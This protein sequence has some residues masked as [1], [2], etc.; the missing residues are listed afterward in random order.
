MSSKIA[1]AKKIKGGYFYKGKSEK[2]LVKK[3]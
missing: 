1:T 2:A 3:R